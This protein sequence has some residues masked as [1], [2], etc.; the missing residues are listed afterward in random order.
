MYHSAVFINTDRLASDNMMNNCRSLY[1]HNFIKMSVVIHS[2]SQ[3]YQD[4]GRYTFTT[5]SNFIKM[6]W[7]FITFLIG[8]YPYTRPMSGHKTFHPNPT[9]HRYS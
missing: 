6:R 3:L 7:W 8:T 2:H 9:L 1:I 5:L 4:V